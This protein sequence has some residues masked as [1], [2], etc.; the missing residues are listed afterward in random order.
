MKLYSQIVLNNVSVTVLFL[1]VSNVASLGGPLQSLHSKAQSRI[2]FKH[3]CL[4]PSCF[5]I[6]T[7]DVRPSQPLSRSIALFHSKSEN[8]S[9]VTEYSTGCLTGA[10]VLHPS[11]YDGRLLKAPQECIIMHLMADPPSVHSPNFSISI[12]K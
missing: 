12:M 4:R 1:Q 8:S 11:L 2:S 9:S 6:Q 10:Q 3:A 5:I 7:V